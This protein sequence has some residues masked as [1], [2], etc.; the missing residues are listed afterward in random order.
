M[1][2]RVGGASRPCHAR[3]RVKTGVPSAK[4]SFFVNRL[5]RRGGEEG[6]RDRAECSCRGR[7]LFSSSGVGSS[8]RARAEETSAEKTRGDETCAESPQMLEAL[9]APSRPPPAPAARPPAAAAAPAPRPRA[10]EPQLPAAA[11]A[12]LWVGGL[13]R[14]SRASA[15]APRTGA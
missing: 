15:P 6:A 7:R 9:A 5:Q 8:G 10:P 2:G 12:A 1:P 4:Q 14:L 11:A 13:P 3:V